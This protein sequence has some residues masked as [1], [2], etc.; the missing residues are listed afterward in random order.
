MKT[1]YFI[2]IIFIFLGL[3]IQAQAQN[4]TLKFKGGGGDNSDF[5]PT[6]P[7]IFPP[8]PTAAE[9]A[10]YGE[11][12]VSYYT[13]TPNI[14]IPI[15]SISS[16]Q[17]SL[18]INL[19]YHSSG[20]KVEDIAP[21]TGYGWSLNAGGVVTRSVVGKPDDVSTFNAIDY[22]DCSDETYN[23][24]QSV[25][26]SDTD[27]EYDKFYFNFLNYSGSFI[28]VNGEAVITPVYQ[29]IKIIPHED[30][31]GT[32]ISF[33]II[34]ADGTKFIFADPELTQI[35]TKTL[36]STAT[37]RSEQYNSSW[38]LTQIISSDKTDVINFSYE[39]GCFGLQSINKSRSIRY[40]YDQ[41]KIA[42]EGNLY[43]GCSLG[44][45]APIVVGE[46]SK[47][48]ISNKFLTEITTNNNDIKISFLT[49]IRNDY[50]S[51]NEGTYTDCKKLDKI[52]IY[53]AN[54]EFRP[55]K[56]H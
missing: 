2:L 44:E 47:T 25:F 22:I 23:Y 6:T 20:I 15:Y 31:Y 55:Q 34:T 35:F 40:L 54:N 9:F 50:N 18:P 7:D 4:D 49:E 5:I 42:A 11:I 39:E 33:T 26:L 53:G 38:Y 8:S 3:S 14:E 17:L 48:Y 24:F 51:G 37:I 52:L 56:F 28:I 41:E 21:W 1:N 19:S 27:S 12:P 16:G 13:G 45:Y 30:S 43:C 32:L 36:G 46:T 29:K 10:K